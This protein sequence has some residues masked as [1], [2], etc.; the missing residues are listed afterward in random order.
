MTWFDQN[1]KP[2]AAISSRLGILSRHV[3]LRLPRRHV[4]QLARWQQRDAFHDPLKQKR[5]DER[6][7]PAT[8]GDQSKT[9]HYAEESGG[10]P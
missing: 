10:R 3:H 4:Q 7:P 5:R 2:A 8:S 1:G 6:S 9:T